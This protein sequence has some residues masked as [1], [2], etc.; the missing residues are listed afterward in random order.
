MVA[1]HRGHAGA[2]YNLGMM[3]LNGIWVDK[4]YFEAYQWFLLSLKNG[5]QGAAK[6]M[7]SIAGECMTPDQVIEAEERAAALFESQLEK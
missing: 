5:D 6:E 4:S 2:Q 1:A 7:L 3:H